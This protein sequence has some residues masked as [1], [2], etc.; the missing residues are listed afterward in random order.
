MSKNKKGLASGLL[1]L[2]VL[3]FMF[4]LSSLL[5][6]TMWTE[7]DNSIQN[8]DNSTVAPEVKEAIHDL[9]SKMLWG[10]KLFAFLFVAMLIA[11]II[12]SVTIP[13]DAPE[14]LFVF[15]IFLILVS[16]LCM[17]FSNTWAYMIEQPNFVEA[18][19]ELPF[20]NYVMNYY[21]IFAFIIGVLGA[22][23]FFA[24]RKTGDN[25]FAFGGGNGGSGGINELVE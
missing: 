6:I 11:Y 22:G 16:V 5:A 23:L 10:D 15:I 7:F 2:I 24:R 3:M 25:S 14:Y 20:T 19:V 1:A 18:A 4:G 8:M 21:P 13:T 17:I 9:G 12:S